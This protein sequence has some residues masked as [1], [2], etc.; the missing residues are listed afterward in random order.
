MAAPETNEDWVRAVRAHD[1]VALEA[2]RAMLLRGLRSGLRANT[3]SD[4]LLQD[5]AQEAMVRI[6]A[7][8]ER[9]R[10]QSTFRAWAL[11]I[12][13]RVAFEELRRARWKDV[14]LES[15]GDDAVDPPSDAPGAERDLARA[16][17]LETLQRTID[18]ALSPRQREVLLGELG[19]VPTA[20]LAQRLGTNANALYKLSHDARVK[21]KQAFEAKGLDASQVRW[22]FE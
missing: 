17:V 14:S 7:A 3:V 9:F 18:E 2:L 11:S 16:Q 19:G 21:L 20:D 4:D 5:F 8:L 22:A 6:N 15:P 1:P 12:A 10:G 13:M